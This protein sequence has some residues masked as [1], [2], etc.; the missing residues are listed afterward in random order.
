MILKSELDRIEFE[1][2]LDREP[3]SDDE[4][5]SWLQIAIRVDSPIASWTC[6]DPCLMICDAHAIARWLADLARDRDVRRRIDFIEPNLAFEMVERDCGVCQLRLCFEFECCPP[7]VKL[8]GVFE[9]FL[10]I[11]VSSE[12]LRL[13]ANQ[14]CEE[15][16]SFPIRGVPP[17]YFFPECEQA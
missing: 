11:R 5:H 1:L 7:V 4:W 16:R 6:T 14:L 8:G 13:A 15:L 9:F 10:P 2:R 17:G 12:E 3:H